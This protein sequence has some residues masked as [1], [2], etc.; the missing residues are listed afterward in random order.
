MIPQIQF[1]KPKKCPFKL[2]RVGGINDGGY[3]IPDDL[4]GIG[5]CFSPG[6]SNTKDFEDELAFK[7]MIKSHMCDFSSDISKFKTK[8]IKNFQTFEKKWL[9]INEDKN[10]IKLEDWVKKYSPNYNEDLILQMDI[11]GAEYRNILDTKMTLMNRFRIIVLELHDVL[12]IFSESKCQNIKL[13]LDKINQTHLCIHAHPNNCDREK[14]Y[15]YNGMNIPNVIELSY[16][17]KDRFRNNAKLLEVDLPNH[18]DIRPNVISRKP[19]H[20]NIHWM[21]SKKRSI[22]SYLKIIK[23]FI[24]YLL[25]HFKKNIKSFISF[26]FKF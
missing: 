5:A 11:E 20:L 2:I 25:H 23:D 14:I 13:L 16:L 15:Q 18:L 7:Y 6:V 26:F 24:P 1:L 10:S 22:R 9:D 12:D 17:R 21:S 8:L 19:I 3:L 4:K